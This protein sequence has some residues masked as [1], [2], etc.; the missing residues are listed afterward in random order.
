[1]NIKDA[2]PE[3]TIDGIVEEII[4]L[5]ILRNLLRRKV[6]RKERSM[7]CSET[8]MMKIMVME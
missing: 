1:M 8:M 6:I 2:K 4:L 3:R 7:L 5:E